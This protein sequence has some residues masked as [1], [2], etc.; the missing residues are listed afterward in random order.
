[1]KLL[2]FVASPRKQGN[3]ALLVQEIL[4]A[5]QEQGAET[6]MIHL[7]DLAMRGCQACLACKKTGTCVLKDDMA[8]LYNQII[9]ADAVVLASPVYMGGMTGQLK[10]FID[11]LYP[12]ITPN[13]TSTLPKGKKAALVFTQGQPRSDIYNPHFQSTANFLKFLGFTVCEKILVAAGVREPGAVT[14]DTVIMEAARALGRQL[15][16][17]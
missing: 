9:A 17:G 6:S 1:M 15:C 7:N 8:P 3:T 13:L 10:L 2:A 11:R 4:K 16:E 5:A 14:K 12:F